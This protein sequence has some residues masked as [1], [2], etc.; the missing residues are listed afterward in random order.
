MYFLLYLQLLELLKEA[1]NLG[2]LRL[3]SLL[4]Q[5]LDAGDPLNASVGG[6]PLRTQPPSNGF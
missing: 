4:K 3:R 1:R 5:L 6:R 2:I